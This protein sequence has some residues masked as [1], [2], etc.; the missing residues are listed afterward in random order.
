MPLF[1]PVT[2]LT[3]T[4]LWAAI[5]CSVPAAR[6]QGAPATDP[7][8][9]RQE[10]DWSAIERALGRRGQLGDGQLY[11]VGMPRSDLSVTV[12]GIPIRPA[13]S[14]GSWVG[15]KSSGDGKVVVMG[16]LVLTEAEL[17][18]VIARLQQ[19]GIGLAAIHK[20]LPDHTPALWWTHIHAHG[21]GV[22]LAA[23]LREALALTGTPAA[24]PAQSPG[25]EASFGIDTAA[26]RHA[27]GRGGRVNGGVYQVGAGRAETVRVM[28]IEVPPAM[29]VG[30]V[31]NFQPTG[32][33]SAVVNGDFAAT[34]T[35]VDS[36]VRALGANR[37]E[38]VSIHNHLVNEE[39]RL[40]FIHFFGHGQA[41]ALA[42]GLRAA[43]DRTN[44]R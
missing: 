22:E 23:T 14:L 18:P 30:T 10:P 25:A 2:A 6:S 11:R 5:A 40:Y 42:R 32:N 4:A 35:E 31:I 34:A 13:L 16:D 36:V 33:G 29:G 41:V 38:V 24:P 44:V 19:G 21:V 15:F 43:L 1:R 8:P 27:L 3:S 17:N 28:G 20:H 26:V 12:R 9:S 7:N 37:I 39:P